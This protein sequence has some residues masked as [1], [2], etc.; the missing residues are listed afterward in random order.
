[1]KIVVGTESKEWMEREE[2][3]RKEQDAIIV[4][5]AG[6]GNRWRHL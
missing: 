1:M 5:I 6:L 3:G 4:L 2:E